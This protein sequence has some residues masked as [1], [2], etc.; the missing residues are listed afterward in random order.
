MK[1]KQPSRPGKVDYYDAK[2][3]ESNASLN[4]GSPEIHNDYSP[5]KSLSINSNEDAKIAYKMQ[6]EEMKKAKKNDLDHLY[7]QNYQPAKF[8]KAV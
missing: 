7:K 1:G 5:T 8:N 2:A 3:E 6:R 4:Y